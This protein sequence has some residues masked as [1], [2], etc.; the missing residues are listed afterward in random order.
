MLSLHITTFTEVEITTGT[1]MKS[2]ASYGV[3]LTF[4]A[5][6]VFIKVDWKNYRA[7][8]ISVA[9]KTYVHFFNGADSTVHFAVNDLL[10]ELDHWV[11]SV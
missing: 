2:F 8:Q 9:T 10:N 1:A 4:I 3:F 5:L 6:E 11:V 7:A